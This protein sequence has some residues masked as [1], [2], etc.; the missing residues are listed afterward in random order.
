MSRKYDIITMDKHNEDRKNML[1]FWNKNKERCML[2]RSIDAVYEEYLAYLKSINVESKINRY[3]FRT[4][5]RKNGYCNS[6]VEMKIKLPKKDRR[7]AKVEKLKAKSE[8]QIAKLEQAKAE[9]NIQSIENI[10][11]NT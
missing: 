9:K 7:A 8:A 1:N 3:I 4:Y 10:E 11:K 5:I 6:G 2:I